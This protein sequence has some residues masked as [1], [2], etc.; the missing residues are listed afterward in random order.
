M[1]EDNPIQ[2]N[3]FNETLL[4]GD[5]NSA[6][7]YGAYS[8]ANYTSKVY[9]VGVIASGAIGSLIITAAA[10]LS[11][12]QDIADLKPAFVPIEGQEKIYRIEGDSF[13]YAFDTIYEVEIKGDIGLYKGV[14]KVEGC[15]EEFICPLDDEHPKDGEGNRMITIDNEEN[16]WKINKGEYYSFRIYA[17]FTYGRMITYEETIYL[18]KE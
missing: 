12:L 8:K 18:A 3:D 2:G 9:K 13:I 16:P 4:E 10:A 15:Y 17:D 1:V 6:H 11:L 14:H 5:L 7:E